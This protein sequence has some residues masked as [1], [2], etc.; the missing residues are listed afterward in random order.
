MNLGFFTM[1]IHPLEKDWRLCLNEDREAFLLADELGFTEGYVGEHVTDRAENITSSVAFI[2]WI[3]AATGQIKLGTGTINMPN[4]HPATVAANIAMLDHMLDG[5]LIF[6]I[7]PGGLLSDAELFGNLDADRN[8]MFLEAI[9]QV[10]AIWESG[11]PYNLQGKYWNVSTQRT[12]MTEIGQGFIA[13][14][15]QRPHPPIVV[16]AVAPFSKGVTEAAARGWEPISANF[17]MPGWVKSHWPRYV[18]GCERAG[19]AASPANWRVAKSVFVA[20]DA[21]TAKAYATDPNSPYVYYYRSL[22]TKLKKNG[23]IELFKTRRD[24]PDEE[25]TLESICDKLIVWGT[26]DSVAD[27]LLAFQDEVGTFGTLLYAGKD[28]KDR[29]LGRQSMILM[30]E[31]VM[32]RI[33]AA[34]RRSNAAG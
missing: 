20:K 27:Q 2:A 18:E 28:W 31:Q 21:A 22:F 4:T 19:R 15:L 12:M 7:S 9:N 6:G 14:P 5:R 17:L 32:P 1:P 8:A 23:R 3:A 11:P 34:S 24:Q 13:R 26:P 29:E 16:T 30:A 33:N 10:L 25:V